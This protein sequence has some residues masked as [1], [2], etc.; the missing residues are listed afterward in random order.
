MI[1][2][3]ISELSFVKLKIYDVLGNEIET[4]VDEYKPAGRYEVEFFV[5][6][7]SSPDIASGVYFYQ[8][9]ATPNGG[10]AGGYLETKKMILMK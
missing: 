7:D 8:L 9:K 10:Q 2:Y 3:Q 4:L 6:Q 1:K 5:G